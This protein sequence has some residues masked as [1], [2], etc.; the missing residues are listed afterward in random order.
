M[1]IKKTVLLSLLIGGVINL[2]CYTAT[3]RNTSFSDE[4]VYFRT[5]VSRPLYVAY[6]AGPVGKNN[7]AAGAPFESTTTMYF[8]GEGCPC[9][10]V[11]KPRVIAN[12]VPTWQFFA[13]WLVWSIPFT[14]LIL[15]RNR[16]ADSGD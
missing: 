12:L 2:F 1:T 14:G 8:I 10:G 3:L 16:Y 4:N 7:F 6:I 13:N 9:N 11:S 15:I 5:K